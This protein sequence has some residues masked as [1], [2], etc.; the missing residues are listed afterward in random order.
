MSWHPT[1]RRPSSC[2]HRATPANPIH[3]A[4][5]WLVLGVPG[6]HPCT[7]QTVMSFEHCSWAFARQSQTPIERNTHTKVSKHTHTHT[8]QQQQQSSTHRGQG[9][10][11]FEIARGL[12]V[13]LLGRIEFFRVQK[14]NQRHGVVIKGVGLEKSG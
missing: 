6:N 3:E 10:F 8:H 13:G 14:P 11:F 4:D 2:F 12:G 7:P 9:V 5:P 1:H